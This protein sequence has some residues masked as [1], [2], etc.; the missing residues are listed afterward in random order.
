M[1]KLGSLEMSSKSKLRYF[2]FVIFSIP[3]FQ[4][5]R[6]PDF[7]IHRF[8]VVAVAGG[9]T[10]AGQTLRSQPDAS[11]NATRDQICCK[12]PGAL[13]AILIVCVEQRHAMTGVVPC[14][15]TKT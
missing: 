2:V 7:Q 11:P 1:I 9:G 8:L 12:E 13:A 15:S 4:I 10:G 3:E 5:P 14:S 6:S